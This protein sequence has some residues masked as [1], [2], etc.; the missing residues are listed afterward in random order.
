MA[1]WPSSLSSFAGLSKKPCLSLSCAFNAG[2]HG[3]S[4]LRVW[5]ATCWSPSLQ[6]PCSFVL[7]SLLD[8]LL[9][10][11]LQGTVLFSLGFRRGAIHISPSSAPEPSSC[12]GQSRNASWRRLAVPPMLAWGHESKSRCSVTHSSHPLSLRRVRAKG[13]LQGG[14]VM[15]QRLEG[16][17]N[18]S[19]EP[20]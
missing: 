6:E 14:G 16:L 3:F 20:V 2:F 1:Y 9:V 19:G 5:Y 12:S 4:S 11:I 15:L 17:A 7:S 18:S 13:L 10:L 8:S